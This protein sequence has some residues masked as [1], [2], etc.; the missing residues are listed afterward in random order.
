MSAP[1]H[2]NCKPTFMLIMHTVITFCTVWSWRT[3]LYGIP[4]LHGS[5]G[6]DCGFPS[7][8]TTQ[9]DKWLSMFQR[10]LTSQHSA[11]N[12][13]TTLPQTQGHNPN[14]RLPNLLVWNKADNSYG[15]SDNPYSHLSDHITIQPRPVQVTINCKL[16]ISDSLQWLDT[17][18]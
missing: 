10:T 5:A 11:Q 14:L 1:W 3:L 13:C 9:C 17:V 8:N 7:Y 16:L 2:S 4:G 6:L 12:T 15:N 18:V